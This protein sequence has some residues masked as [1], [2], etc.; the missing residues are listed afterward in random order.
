MTSTI[1]I[2][3]IEI[4]VPQELIAA[5]LMG[6]QKEAPLFADYARQWFERYKRPKLREKTNLLYEGFL[7]N[8]LIPFFGQKQ[9][10]AI[11]SEEIQCFYDAKA[12]LS[13]STTRQMKVVLH[14]ILDSAIEDGY[15]QDNPTE[16]KRHVLPAKVTTRNAL[17]ADEIHD[18]IRQMVRLK[19][20]DLLLLSLLIYTGERRGEVLGLRWEDIDFKNNMISV[21]R[22]VV[23]IRNK[24][25]VGNP[26]S[27]AGK[28]K[29]PLLPELKEI[30][31]RYRKAE[32]YIIGNGTEP[33]S[34]KAFDRRYERIRRQVDLHGATPHVFRHTFLTMASDKI[35]PKTLQAIAGH[36]TFSLTFNKYVHKRDDKVQESATKLKQ[37]F[38]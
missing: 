27:Q 1:T 14:Q 24:P 33:I 9:V 19:P 20:Q 36:S 5:M 18:V 21:S 25:L 28:R 22:A 30:L 15:R 6:Q 10:G 37:L 34:E 16:S 35:D 23:H 38:A 2:N 12:D 32:G 11:T 3:G 31:L 7:E 8:H 4:P 26:K 17:T 29:V 13:H